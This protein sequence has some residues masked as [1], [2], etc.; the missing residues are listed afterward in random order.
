MQE[1][2]N[3]V[4]GAGGVVL[5]NDGMRPDTKQQIIPKQYLEDATRADRQPEQFRPGKATPYFGYGYQFWSFP[6]GKHRFAAQGSYGQVIFVDP[7]LKLVLVLT[8]ANQTAQTGKTTLG[9]ETIAFWR[10]LV[11]NWGRW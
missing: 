9:A 8:T 1:P 4:T 7:E 10:G 2:S 6:G 11:D 5:A 3:E